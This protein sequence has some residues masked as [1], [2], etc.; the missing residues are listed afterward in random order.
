MGTVSWTRGD[1]PLVPFAEGFWRELLR[2]G[3]PPG[4]AKHHLVLMG[5]LN[6]WL[7]GEGLGCES[8]LRRWP[9]SSWPSGGL[10]A[11]DVCPRSRP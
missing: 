4:G 5:Q 3:H 2:L 11:I 8:S 1:G 6:R 10:A 9:G 7:L